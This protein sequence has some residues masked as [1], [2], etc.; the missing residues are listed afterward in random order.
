M[1][2]SFCGFGFGVAAFAAESE[3]SGSP[4]EAAGLSAGALKG[5]AGAIPAAAFDVR[6]E[7]YDERWPDLNHENNTPYCIEPVFQVRRPC[8]LQR[9]LTRRE[10]RL[11]TLSF[12]TA[13]CLPG[14]E[15]SV[16]LA[17]TVEPIRHCR[18]MAHCREHGMAE[19]Q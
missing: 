17:P 13:F 1:G 16:S 19:T 11:R 3:E 12:P 2:Q 5:S 6:L 14:A 4:L 7:R 8:D 10:R 9:G 15:V 18:P